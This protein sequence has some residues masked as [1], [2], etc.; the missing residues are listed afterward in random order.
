MRLRL[1]ISALLYG[2]LSF[3]ISSFAAEEA[4]WT[5]L[6][7]GKDLDGWQAKHPEL[8][9]VENGMLI[10]RS[11]GVKENNFIYTAKK[12][13]D[14][15]LRY[16]LRLVKDEGNTGVQIRS[17]SMQDGHAVGYQVDAAKG[18]WGCLYHEGPPAEGARGMLLQYK[19]TE[20]AKDDPIK[21]DQF[22]HFEVS[23]HGHHITITINGVKTV[24]LEDPKGE[25]EGYIAPQIHAGVPMEVQIKN[26][27]IREGGRSGANK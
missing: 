6:F 3:S 15:D 5:P 27:E 1:F 25:L 22:N 13:E 24:D 14:F 21:L 12:Y 16:D 18:Y 20:G 19:R 4:K 7:N 11:P 8:W 10:G 2:L 26:M 9:V 23:A 17:R